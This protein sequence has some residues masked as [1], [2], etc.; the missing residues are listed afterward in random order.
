MNLHRL[1]AAPPGWLGEALERFEARFYYPLGEGIKFRISHGR[2]YIS[3]FEAMGDATVWVAERSGEVVGTLAAI[4]R[5]LHLPGGEVRRVAY[6]CDLKVTPGPQAGRA[7]ASLAGATVKSLAGKGI[8]SAYSVVMGGTSR[9]PEGYTGRLDIPQFSPLGDIVVFKVTAP[10]GPRPS[11]GANITTGEDVHAVYESLNAS[12][13][14]A[15]ACCPSLRSFEAPVPL[16]AVDGQACGIIDD[17]RRGKRLWLDTGAE[18]RA[19]HL[20][21]FSYA[22]VEAGANLVRHAMTI[23]ARQGVP[24]MF[25]AVPSGDAPCFAAALSDHSPHM[26]PARIYGC[27]LPTTEA[28]SVDTS[29]I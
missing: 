3:F 21:R 27:G 18:L 22:N 13:V 4:V 9:S 10:R 15:E 23:V 5:S 7:L 20:S 17:T 25:F 19:A 8:Q 14:S 11:S 12:R 24:T 16:L 29:E 26:A 2:S 6:L 1:S 28:W